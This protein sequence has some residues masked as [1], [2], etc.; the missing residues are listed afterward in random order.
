MLVR[1]IIQ[2]I[3]WKISYVGPARGSV[4]GFYIAYLTKITQLNPLK[5]DL[6]EWRHLHQ[7]RP[8]LPDYKIH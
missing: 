4:T 6:P 2:D 8:E 7:D 3:M 5:Y 1:N